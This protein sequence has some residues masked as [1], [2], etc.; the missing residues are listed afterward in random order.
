MKKTAVFVA[1]LV[2][3]LGGAAPAF[4]DAEA[5]GLAVGSSGLFSGNVFQFPV[6]NQI[7]LCGNTGGLFSLLSPSIGT[8][9]VNR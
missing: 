3:A 8:V 6:H 9:C 7:N 4:A 5:N 1:G 2:L